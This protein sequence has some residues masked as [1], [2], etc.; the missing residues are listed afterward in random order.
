MWMCKVKFILAFV[1]MMHT[2][3]QSY[4]SKSWASFQK[5]RC[6]T[7]QLVCVWCMHDSNLTYQK[8]VW[9]FVDLMQNKIK[10]KKKR[11]EKE[12]PGNHY[13]WQELA[14]S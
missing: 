4:I 14:G 5:L 3:H 10:V 8:L 12:I 2:W 9:A 6:R 1:I 13:I 11:K 7:P